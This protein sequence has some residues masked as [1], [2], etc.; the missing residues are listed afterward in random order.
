MGLL[1]WNTGTEFYFRTLQD[2]YF[3]SLNWV[4]QVWAK[5]YN[6][7]WQCNTVL[8]WHVQMHGTFNFQKFL[9]RMTEIEFTF[10][11]VATFWNRR[12]LNGMLK[13]DGSLLSWMTTS[14]F[15]FWNT[16][17]F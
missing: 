5:S 17:P 13:Q 6:L 7:K 12:Q 11:N 14:E 9:S 4:L 15:T 3:Q 1:M 2:F 8:E 16:A 10:Y